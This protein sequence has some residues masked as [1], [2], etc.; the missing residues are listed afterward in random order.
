MALDVHVVQLHLY[1]KRLIS[2]IRN[3]NILVEID[4][5]FIANEAVSPSTIGND[6]FPL[7]QN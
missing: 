4:K 3:L 2:R 5:L 1:L 7:F 6:V